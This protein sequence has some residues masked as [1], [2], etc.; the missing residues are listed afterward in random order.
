M[1]EIFTF[2]ASILDKAVNQVFRWSI[3][4][5]KQTLLLGVI[6]DDL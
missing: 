3:Q 2:S 4:I 1:T 5:F 6:D